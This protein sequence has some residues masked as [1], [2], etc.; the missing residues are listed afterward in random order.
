MFVLPWTF[1]DVAAIR[2]ALLPQNLG[3]LGS[4]C[5]GRA[6]IKLQTKLHTEQMAGM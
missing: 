1:A 4:F 2:I 5:Y 6:G 3:S